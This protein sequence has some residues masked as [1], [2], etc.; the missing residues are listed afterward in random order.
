LETIFLTEE[1]RLMRTQNFREKQSFQDLLSAST[2]H[3]PEDADE[4][5]RDTDASLEHR[6]TTPRPRSSPAH[7]SGQRRVL[8]GDDPEAAAAHTR[9]RTGLIRIDGGGRRRQA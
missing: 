3:V 1:K 4:D 6:P 9:V 5:A 8:I 7:T 2:T